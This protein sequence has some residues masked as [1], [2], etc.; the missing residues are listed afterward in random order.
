MHE[1]D[2]CSA[3]HGSDCLRHPT[4]GNAWL[5]ERLSVVLSLTSLMKACSHA[6]TVFTDVGLGSPAPATRGR[7]SQAI[8]GPG[9]DIENCACAEDEKE[10]VDDKG[11]KPMRE[12]DLPQAQDAEEEEEG[13]DSPGNRTDMELAW[14]NLEVAKLIYERE[15]AASYAK[16]IAGKQ[17]PVRVIVGL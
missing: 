6:L 15:N 5:A 9:T 17:F 13:D 12:E 10:N 14:E 7:K 2:R 8:R 11:K 4:Y 3:A 16:E 1:L